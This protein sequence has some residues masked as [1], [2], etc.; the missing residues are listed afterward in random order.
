MA[1]EEKP[2]APCHCA[3]KW[4]MGCV[5]IVLL[6]V[7]MLYLLLFGLAQGKKMTR[8]WWTS[9]MTGFV[10]AFL[11]YEPIV[12]GIL[13]VAIPM[14]IRRKM[15]RLVDPTQLTRFPFKTQLNEHP[16]TYLA[17]KHRG[18][19]V[20][21][22]ILRR[23]AIIAGGDESSGSG[24]GGMV[25]NYASAT[26]SKGTRMLL[27][28]LGL[29]LMLPEEAQAMVL[30][31]LMGMATLVLLL[32]IK[33]ANNLARQSLMGGAGGLCLLV[34]LFLCV[35]RQ[36]APKHDDADSDD[37]E[38]RGV[39]GSEGS[40]VLKAPIATLPAAVSDDPTAPGIPA[41]ETADEL[42]R[43]VLRL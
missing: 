2:P 15:K 29:L 35:R 3:T 40:G 32:L 13:Y 31:D 43:L 11:I 10:L 14:T 33:V 8:T 18:L 6:I 12:I 16:T 36:K 22:G 39:N 27:V 19:V 26:S 30:E 9:T 7:P 37:D 4:F 28:L 34:M 42:R 24:G 1:E 38:D 5:V 41:T 21:R 23:R 20:A 17:H 25:F